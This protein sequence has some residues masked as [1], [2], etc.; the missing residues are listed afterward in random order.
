[1]DITVIVVESESYAEKNNKI[2]KNRLADFETCRGR[3]HLTR[4]HYP[5]L[6]GVC[7]KSP[8]N[9]ASNRKKSTVVRKCD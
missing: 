3:R 8:L 9:N 4:F 6:K 7:A 1:M 5:T 2:F